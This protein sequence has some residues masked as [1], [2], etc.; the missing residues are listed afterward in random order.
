M[1]YSS[2]DY[3]LAKDTDILYLPLS[4]TYERFPWRA[5]VTLSHLRITGPGGV[6]GG[7]EGGVIVGGGGNGG[8]RGE[9]VI[10]RK[11][12]YLTIRKYSLYL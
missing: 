12:W 5:T 10:L 3:G 2:G 8:G 9:G 1:D 6:T 4:L 7:G 11:P